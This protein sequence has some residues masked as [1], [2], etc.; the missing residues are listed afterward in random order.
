LAW[1]GVHSLKQRHHRGRAT[2][3]V[4]VAR[5]AED[6]HE[7]V[8][9]ERAGDPT[10]PG[11]GLKPEVHRALPLKSQR[12]T[13]QAWTASRLG[14]PLSGGELVNR[15]GEPIAANQSRYRI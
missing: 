15:V 11:L 3:S 8:L 10:K 13:S 5:V 14:L 7:G 12:K 4:G 1:M 9:G 2:V 6:T